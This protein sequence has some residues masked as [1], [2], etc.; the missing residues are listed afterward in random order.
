[1][2][3]GLLFTPSRTCYPDKMVT[4][5]K[6]W[7]LEDLVDFEVAVHQSPTVDAEVG[8]EVR[9]GLRS[10][11]GDEAA[12]RRWGLKTWLQSK[13][14]GNGAKVVSVTRL[15][16]LALLIGTFLVGVGVIRGMVITKDG[17]AV[18]NM[19]VLLAGTLGIQWLVLLGGLAAF[20]LFRY[21]IGG[22][23]WLREVISSVVRKFA[24]MVSSE[25]WQS[26]IQGKGKQPSA[27]AWRLTRVLQLG[28]VGFNVGLVAGLFGL[29]L[30]KEVGFYWETSLSQ[31]GG[32]SLGRTTRILASVWGGHGLNAD[33]I[34][35]L[36]NV[37][38]EGREA[39][40]EAFA[41]FIFVAFVV[42]GLVP[43]MLLWGFAVWKERKTLASLDFQDQGHRKLW[44]EL[45]RVERS[46]T[47][48]GMKDGV[49]LLD[50]GGTGLEAAKIRPFLLKNLRVN[51]EKSF[52]VGILDA[53]E[54]QEAWDAM[55]S[56]PCGVV[57]LVEGWSLS[58]KQMVALLE[59]IRRE[60]GAETV[61]R[62]LV[63][64]D[65]LEE[66]DAEDFAGWQGFVDGLRDPRLECVSYQE[67]SNDE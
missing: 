65:G 60:A 41:Q 57:M 53:K 19:W 11:K 5:K 2:L 46:V 50:V 26:L 25:A 43:R 40:W 1:M 14:R 61:L 66:P 7:K 62:I 29:L 12:K 20:L 55:R 9:E 64:G 6:G 54:E 4:V 38:G 39:A 21:W 33:E 58:P 35:L 34:A 16:G 23:G 59:R 37:D 63:M 27:M 56:A 49:V 47:M 17:Q 42:W 10:M 67:G 28:G 24:G 15:V 18:I 36:K 52:A 45:S 32:E 48:E 51:P 13:P 44:R 30:F 3:M 31:F 8:R 22:L